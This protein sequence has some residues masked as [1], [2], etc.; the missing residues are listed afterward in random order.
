M[1][2]RNIT[3]TL[4]EELV[5]RAKIVAATRDTSVSRLVAD[6]LE[7]LTGEEDDYVERWQ[8]ERQLMAQGLP[9]RI[10]DVTWG[11]DDLHER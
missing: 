1:S 4:P 11:R 6:F 5:Q 7:R 2:S 8:E 10:G 9:M 3:L